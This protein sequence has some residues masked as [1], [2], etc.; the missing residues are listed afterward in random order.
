M[1]EFIEKNRRLL[2]FCCDALRSIGQVVLIL[3]VLSVC[4][5]TTLVLFSKFGNWHA[6]EC[7]K[8]IIAMMPLGA[9]NIIFIGIGILGLAQFIR[10]LVERDYKPGWILRHGEMFFYL[11]ALLTI[12]SVVWVYTIAP[13]DF[14][15]DMYSGVSVILVVISTAVKVLILVGLGQ[16]LRRLMPVIEESKSLV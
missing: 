9:F 15:P 16:I 1:N 12:L 3:G 11:Y 13:S 4:A 14:S 8:M 5:I 2:R 10:Y 7:F 6:P